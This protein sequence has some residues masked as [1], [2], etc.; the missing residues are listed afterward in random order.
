MTLA[1]IVSVAMG[2]A[3]ASSRRLHDLFAGLFEDAHR[4]QRRRRRRY[5]V[6]AVVIACVAGGS[7][8]LL[9]RSNGTGLSHAGFA[10]PPRM[11]LTSRVLPALGG[12]PLLSVAGGRLVVAESGDGSVVHGRVEGNCA[13]AS[14]DPTTLRATSVARGSCGDPALFG[15]HVM[16]ITY[17]PSWRRIAIRIATVDRAAP[18]GYRLGPVI[19]TYPNGSDVR[20]QTIQGDGSLWVYA[21]VVNGRPK[22]GEV[23]RVSLTTGRVVEHWKMPQIGRALLATDANGLWLAP[24]NESG[25]PR[26]GSPS[27]KAVVGSLYR[28]APGG[29]APERVFDTGQYGARWLVA[30]GRSVWVDVGRARATPAVWRFDGASATPVI[31]AAPAIG[32]LRQCADLGEGSVTIVASASGIYCVNNPGPNREGVYWLGSSGGQSSV[33]ASVSTPAITYEFPDNAVL[34]RGDYYFVDPPTPGSGRPELYRVA[35]H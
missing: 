9:A 17:L 5:V 32:G 16:P 34:Y 33:V 24:S 20:A 11:T 8:V 15:E 6:L 2:S 30:Y 23:L 4:F 22:V 3:V 10:S 1:I 28:L 31:R 14:V 19:V 27:Q 21:P 25:I 13:A 18:A 12:N 35:P 26:H 7:V 29:R